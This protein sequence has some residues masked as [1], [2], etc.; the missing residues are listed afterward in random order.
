[1]LVFIG[2]G[3]IAQ[4]LLSKKLTIVLIKL[5]ALTRV[6][7]NTELINVRQFQLLAKQEV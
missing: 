2:D 6:A 7:N 4:G 5:T 3:E 1:V